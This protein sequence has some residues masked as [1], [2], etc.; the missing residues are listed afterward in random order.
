MQ[1]DW[2]LGKTPR[3]GSDEAIHSTCRGSPGPQI[4]MTIC[5]DKR[6][7]NVPHSLA[8]MFSIIPNHVPSSGRGYACAAT[9]PES[10]EVY[11]T[12]HCDSNLPEI[13]HG[14]GV[15]CAGNG[16]RDDT[17][18]VGEHAVGTPRRLVRHARL[19]IKGE[20]SRAERI[21]TAAMHEEGSER[22]QKVPSNVNH[23]CP[24]TWEARWTHKLSCVANPSGQ[25]GPS[26]EAHTVPLNAKS[27]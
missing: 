8:M 24:C 15:I 9:Q 20:S 3:F 2:R 6:R 18:A 19:G 11:F 25:V 12:E 23:H 10:W 16:L 13:R 22:V 4:N 26:R 17:H 7:T 27:A 1:P 21:L 5:I 14:E